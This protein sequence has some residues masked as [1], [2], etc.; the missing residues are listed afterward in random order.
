[1]ETSPLF[2]ISVQYIP[3]RSSSEPDLI[4]K[5]EKLAFSR[6]N[7]SRSLLLLERDYGEFPLLGDPFF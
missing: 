7:Y 2:I 3:R 6:H 1:M 5:V 4:D